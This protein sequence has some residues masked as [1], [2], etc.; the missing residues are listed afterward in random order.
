MSYFQE[1]TKNQRTLIHREVTSSTHSARIKRRGDISISMIYK[2][3]FDEFVDEVAYSL[4]ETNFLYSFNQMNINEE[5]VE[6]MKR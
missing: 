3:S 1:S 5:R 6:R 2:E 4:T